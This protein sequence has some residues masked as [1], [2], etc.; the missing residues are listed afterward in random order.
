MDFSLRTHRKICHLLLL[1]LWLPR[2][3]KYSAFTHTRE[4]HIC[5]LTHKHTHTT[6]PGSWEA[7]RWLTY[8]GCWVWRQEE[9]S[10]YKVSDLWQEK[11]RRCKEEVDKHKLFSFFLLIKKLLPFHGFT[12]RKGQIHCSTEIK[13]NDHWSWKVMTS[14]GKFFY[15]Y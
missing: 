5:A 1:L 9:L 7:V 2:A 8:I 13:V 11:L 4:T 10:A 12:K 15:N 3:R 14:Q 6:Q